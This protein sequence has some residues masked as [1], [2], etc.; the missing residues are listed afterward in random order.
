MGAAASMDRWE[1][2]FCERL[3]AARTPR[4]PLQP[5]R[6]RRLD[7]VAAGTAGLHGRRPHGRRA[8]RCSTTS[9][10]SAPTSSACP[11]VPGIAQRLVLG[12]PERSAHPDAHVGPRP[13]G[14]RS[15]GP[16]TLP[17]MSAE[18]A[19]RVRR[20][21]AADEPD[22]ADRARRSAPD[23]G[24][25]TV[26]GPAWDRRGG[27]AGDHGPRLRPLDRLPARTTTSSSTER[28][29]RARLA[30]ITSPTLVVHGTAD[31][32]FPTA[33]GEALA[34]EI[35]GAQLLLI[36]GIGHEFPRWAWD[37]LLRGGVAA[38]L[39]R[40]GERREAAR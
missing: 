3:A 9:A 27:T 25:T 2:P 30:E 22:W 15:H 10:S 20:R 14:P 1:Q 24:R 38:A 32:L 19:R 26:R 23:R 16:E 28:H 31:P 5:P 36:E 13:I 39:V 37:E 40:R 11:W 7:D 6:H 18:P 35:P 34:R 21:R 12:H 4:H 8:R 17:G 29:G 33:H